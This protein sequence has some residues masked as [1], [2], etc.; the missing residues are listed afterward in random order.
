V[1]TGRLE[2]SPKE[3]REGIAS[4]YYDLTAATSEAQ[5]GAILELV[6][7]SQLVMDLISRLC[8]I[9]ICPRHSRYR[10]LPGIQRNRFAGPLVWQRGSFVT[11]RLKPASNGAWAQRLWINFGSRWHSA[12]AAWPAVIFQGGKKA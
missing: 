6:P 2:L 3:V 8:E 10:S 1:G 7:A 4:F 5:L 11:R 12:S 9:D